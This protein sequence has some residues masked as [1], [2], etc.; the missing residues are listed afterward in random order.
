MDVWILDPRLLEEASARGVVLASPITLIALLRTVSHGWTTEA[1][2]DATREIHELGRELHARL[3]T[4]GGHLDKVGRSLKASVEAYNA[5][6]GSLETRVLVTAR[7]FD[8]IGLG[9]QQL[10]SPTPVTSTPRPLTP[11]CSAAMTVVPEPAKGSKTC[12][13]PVSRITD[14]AQSAEKP[15]E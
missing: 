7:Q 2:A 10:E 4:M 9:E 13:A 5:T 11:S 14:R 1:L 15:A 6:I 12:F 3:A 8:D